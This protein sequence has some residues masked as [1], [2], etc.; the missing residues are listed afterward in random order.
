MAKQNDFVTLVAQGNEVT[1]RNLRRII[2][3]DDG[4]AQIA[5]KDFPLIMQAKADGKARGMEL[6][7]TA[8]PA[9]YSNA[10]K[11]NRAAAKERDLTK[12]ADW[13]VY[14]RYTSVASKLNAKDSVKCA[15]AVGA[16]RTMLASLIQ[17]TSGLVAGRRS[18]GLNATVLEDD[19]A[20]VD[21]NVEA[22]EALLFD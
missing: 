8:F 5:T 7:A 2:A 10:P 18:S 14:R 6:L 12:A 3:A 19:G 13:S 20:P 11:R 4:F 1:E 16:I 17:H 22:L 15:A 9:E 21:T